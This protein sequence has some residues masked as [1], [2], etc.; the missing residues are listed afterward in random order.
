MNRGKVIENMLIVT[1]AIMVLLTIPYPEKIMSTIVV[2]LLNI[3]VE[4]LKLNGKD[5]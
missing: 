5:R 3:Y 1:V 2:L 4:L